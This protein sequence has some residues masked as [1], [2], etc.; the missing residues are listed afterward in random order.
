MEGTIRYPD[1]SS[2]ARRDRP[3]HIVHGAD[4][5]RRALYLSADSIERVRQSGTGLQT[6]DAYPDL[7]VQADAD[8]S[9]SVAGVLVEA[10]HHADLL[11]GKELWSAS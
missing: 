4:T 8:K 10:S 5:A 1:I 6:R 9:M 7:T 2:A 11:V 3:L